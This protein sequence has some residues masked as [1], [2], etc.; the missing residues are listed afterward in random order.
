MRIKDKIPR[1]YKSFADDRICDIC[2]ISKE[3]YEDTKLK[4]AIKH[5]AEYKCKFR[6][7]ETGENGNYYYM[8]DDDTKGSICV[9]DLN[10]FPDLLREEKLKKL[11]EQNIYNK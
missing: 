10:C 11:N 4:K 5:K 8:C 6:R 1:C 9:P 7:T 2:Y 3:C